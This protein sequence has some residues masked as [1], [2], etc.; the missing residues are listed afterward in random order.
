VFVPN[1]RRCRAISR[2]ASALPIFASVH[3]FRSER[4]PAPL[5]SDSVRPAG[6]RKSRTRPWPRRARQ[7]SRRLH[8]D[9]GDQRRLAL[10]CALG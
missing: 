5:S 4:R 7:S 9:P 6:Y 8:G 3:C 2:P 10:R 1:S